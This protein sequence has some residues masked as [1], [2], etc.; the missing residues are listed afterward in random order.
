MNLHFPGLCLLFS[1]YKDLTNE[2]I[3]EKTELSNSG[4]TDTFKYGVDEMR[5][6]I[7]KGIDI[8]ISHIAAI[9]DRL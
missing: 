2:A 9:P 4:F 1:C 6:Q 5:S 8:A 7:L 3:L